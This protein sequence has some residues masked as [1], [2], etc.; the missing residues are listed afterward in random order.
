MTKILKRAKG[1]FK[2]EG[3]QS[4]IQDEESVAQRRCPPGNGRAHA[5]STR[6]ETPA[7]NS[8]DE[9]TT[10]GML[11]TASMIQVQNQGV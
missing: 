9:K 3:V 6:N 7:R 2:A 8:C 5:A 11:R 4:S 1:G 10:E